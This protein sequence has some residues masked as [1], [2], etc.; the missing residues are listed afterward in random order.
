MQGTGA[1]DDLIGLNIHDLT[2]PAHPTDDHAR[3]GPDITNSTLRYSELTPA[4][5]LGSLSSWLRSCWSNPSSPRESSASGSSPIARDPSVDWRALSR[6]SVAKLCK[7]SLALLAS[8]A[9]V[10]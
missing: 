4:S 2:A 1:D 6:R 7:A 10:S 9:R 8:L 3:R 5:L